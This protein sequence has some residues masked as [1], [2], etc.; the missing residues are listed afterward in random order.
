M[1]SPTDVAAFHAEYDRHP[2]DRVHLF[3]AVA[4][5]LPDGV[6][7]LY[8]GSYVDI[9]PSVWFDDVTYVDV[10]KRAP[11]FFAQHDAVL[12]LIGTKRREVGQPLAP[13]PAVAFH[14]LDYREPLPLSDDSF[15]L[16]I[17]LYAGF[18][19]EHCTRYLKSGGL[20]LVNGSHGDAAMASLDA[21]CELVAVLQKRTGGYQ[22][23]CDDLD[24][25]LKPKRGA[26]PTV[27]E[28]HESN[29]GIAYTKPAFAYV[30]R[31]R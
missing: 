10:D 23:V 7:V 20:L 21:N 28:L 14:H 25:Y 29:R 13:Q 4:E 3:G 27:A 1:T 31:R 9:G 12:D 30:F 11:R 16:L 24:G 19:S 8:P 26:A 6:K 15:D 17:S 18:I 5:L 22:A 2:D